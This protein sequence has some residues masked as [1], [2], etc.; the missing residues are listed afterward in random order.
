MT[1][2]ENCFEKIKSNLDNEN[3]IVIQGQRSVGKH[4]FLKKLIH[5]LKEEKK[6]PADY[7]FYYGLDDILVQL[8]FKDQFDA[9]KTELALKT[10]QALENLKQSIYLFFEQIQNNLE[11]LDLI[12]TIRQICPTKIK[13]VMTSSIDLTTEKIFQKFLLP[14]ADIYH[15]NPVTIQELISGE[16]APLNGE[17]ILKAIVEGRFDT[18]YFQHLQWIVEPYKNAIL[19]F[20]EEYLLY[21]SLPS[22]YK[23]TENEKEQRWHVIRHFL[24]RYFEHDLRIVYQIN[25]LKKFNR[26]LEIMVNNNGQIVNLLKLC[27]Y[28][29]FNRNTIRKYTGI[30]SE[31]FLIDFLDPYLKEKIAKPIMRTPKLYFLDPGLV[32]YIMHCF[33]FKTL[34]KTQIKTIL[35]T[36]LYLNLK[37]TIH[38][39][40]CACKI[41]FLRDYQEHELDFLI[42]VGDK[43]TPVG[44]VYNAE[45]RK[46]KVK[47][48]RYYLR[49]CQQISNGVIFGN[50]DKSEI[51]EMRGSK[52][53]L[54]PL[55]MLW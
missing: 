20:L 7:L 21:G 15:V 36:A 1:I 26:V 14:Q 40:G 23:F 17:S 10:G 52:L 49:Y 25:E 24:R 5:Y 41:Y 3:V 6:V 51:I 48:F 55:W 27:D 37:N 44:I 2:R 33:D 46:V 53:F 18:D 12:S 28:Y 42:S 34:E 32:N 45:Q 8:A 19:H 9:F 30:L 43:M 38:N 22:V 47:T 39:L 35:E 4:S 13:I 50:F 16:I 54:F 29:H 31:T 11:L